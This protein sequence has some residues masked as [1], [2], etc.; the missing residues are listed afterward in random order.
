MNLFWYPDCAKRSI[1]GVAEW[2]FAA[3][4]GH[5][6]H[7]YNRGSEAGAGLHPGVWSS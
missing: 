1:G 7:V 4:A 5:A 3:G 6:D 2:G